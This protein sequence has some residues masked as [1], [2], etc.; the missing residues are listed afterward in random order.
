[1]QENVIKLFFK[2]FALSLFAKNLACLFD[3]L[4][5]NCQCSL[6]FF[7][8]TGLEESLE[9]VLLQVPYQVKYISLG[10]SWTENPTT[11]LYPHHLEKFRHLELLDLS[12]N[13]I[14]GIEAHTFR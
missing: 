4:S 8:C 6:Q 11:H 9:I 13:K 1:M 12:R 14:V 2:S 3:Q 10:K 7:N 5:D